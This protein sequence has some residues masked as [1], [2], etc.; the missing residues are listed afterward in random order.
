MNKHKILQL[1]ELEQRNAP[2]G[3]GLNNALSSSGAVPPI[4]PDLH[5]R[6]IVTDSALSNPGAAQ[7]GGNATAQLQAK[8]AAQGSFL[9]TIGGGTSAVTAA[10][11]NFIKIDYGVPAESVSLNF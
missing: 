3:V 5:L 8:V 6:R 10:T 2:S 7:Y 4:T 11:P 9:Q 1:E